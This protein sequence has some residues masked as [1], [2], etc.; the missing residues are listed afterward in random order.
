MGKSEGEVSTGRL[1]SSGEVRTERWG[2]VEKK[3]EHGGVG[4]A[5]EENWEK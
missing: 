5:V 2:A 3:W 4:E 1:G